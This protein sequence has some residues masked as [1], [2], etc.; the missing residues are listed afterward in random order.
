MT[1][2]IQVAFSTSTHWRYHTKLLESLGAAFPATEVHLES[3]EE[4][5]SVPEFASYIAS[6]EG[7]YHA[8]RMPVVVRVPAT[9]EQFADF[10][11]AFGKENEFV[12]STVNVFDP[13]KVNEYFKVMSLKALIPI[14]R[15]AGQMFSPSFSPKEL[16]AVQVKAQR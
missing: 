8:D 5:M 12:L 9:F 14:L 11:E 13:S 15:T 7:G 4:P 1:Y 10:L 6:L 3:S 16:M 2:H